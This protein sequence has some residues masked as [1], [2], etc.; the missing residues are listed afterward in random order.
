M[1]VLLSVSVKLKSEM[2][3][4]FRMKQNSHSLTK[5]IATK[6]QRKPMNHNSIG[7]KCLVVFKL[8]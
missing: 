3:L 7:N 1:P 5:G 4:C 2:S 6:T 8:Y